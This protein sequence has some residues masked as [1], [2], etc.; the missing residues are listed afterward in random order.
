MP[1]FL[2]LFAATTV[3]LLASVSAQTEEIGKEQDRDENWRTVSALM[4]IGPIV[5]V[6]DEPII[7]EARRKYILAELEP[8]LAYLHQKPES[9]KVLQLRSLQRQ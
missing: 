2:F 7:Q 6:I 4:R 9:R 1:K 5:D 8:L 3:L